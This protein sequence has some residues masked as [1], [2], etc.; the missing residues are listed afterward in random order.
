[1][2]H[3]W[4]RLMSKAF[5]HPS[6]S[7]NYSLVFILAVGFCTLNPPQVAANIFPSLSRRIPSSHLCFHSCF[8]CLYQPLFFSV[9][10]PFSSR[11]TGLLMTSLRFV[12]KLA[13]TAVDYLTISIQHQRLRRDSPSLAVRQRCANTLWCHAHMNINEQ[14]HATAVP[15]TE[16]IRSFYSEI[17]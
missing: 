8:C 17:C 5:Y 10:L 12:S 15:Q 11:D 4:R 16:G 14:P 2:A 13:L 3:K 9:S 7:V 1:M 6:D